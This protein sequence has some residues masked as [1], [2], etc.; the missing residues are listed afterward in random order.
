MV[1][2]HDRGDE[3]QQTSAAGESRAERRKPAQGETLASALLR[4]NK[5]TIDELTR[6]MWGPQRAR[7]QEV[8]RTTM[9]AQ[10]RRL[11]ERVE[12]VASEHYSAQTSAALTAIRETVLKNV[13]WDAIRTAFLTEQVHLRFRQNADQLF[14]S[15]VRL[16]GNER[17][18]EAI[19]A[20]SRRPEFSDWL[21][22]CSTAAQGNE[23]NLDGFDTKTDDLLATDEFRAAAEAIA[24]DPETL[25]SLADVAADS[26]ASSAADD[27]TAAAGEGEGS[28]ADAQVYRDLLKILAVGNVVGV[29]IVIG[30]MSGQF[31]LTLA[32]LANIA[33]ASG[34]SLRDLLKMHK[35]D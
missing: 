16:N 27:D 10:N 18:R 24:D 7:L 1:D 12:L 14:E 29:C 13:D 5:R 6:Q 28:S 19:V 2:S 21:A 17:V 8:M 11:I 4:Q 3:K 22:T 25:A 20:M 23:E 31:L 9:T 35:D 32:L 15:F 26:F 30:V 34:Y 33:Q